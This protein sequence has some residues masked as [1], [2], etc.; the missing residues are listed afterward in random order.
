M[1]QKLYLLLLLVTNSIVAQHVDSTTTKLSSFNDDGYIYDERTYVIYT[2]TGFTEILETK[3]QFDTAFVFTSASR[4]DVLHE[5][6]EFNGSYLSSTTRWHWDSGWQQLNRTMFHYD[7]NSVLT[8][9]VYQIYSGTWTDSAR[10]V[11]SWLASGELTEQ[12]SQMWNGSSWDNISRVEYFF[13]TYLQDT[14]TINYTGSGSVWTPTQKIVNQY[15]TLAFVI[16]SST[17][18]T[19]NVSVWENELLHK[20]SYGNLYTDIMDSTFSWDGSNWLPLTLQFSHI[21]NFNLV[22]STHSSEWNGSSWDSTGYNLY[23]RTSVSDYNYQSYFYNGDGTYSIMNDFTY[24]YDLF[25]RLISYSYD[26]HMGSSMGYFFY[27]YDNDG[28][29]IEFSKSTS[30]MGGIFGIE[31]SYYTKVLHSFNPSSE[32]I[33]CNG[34]SVT[35]EISYFGGKGGNTYSWTGPG[36]ISN[37][38]DAV[39]I[40]TPT[41]DSYFYVSIADTAGNIYK[42]SVHVVL[43]AFTAPDLGDDTTLCN[44]SP[45]TL[46]VATGYD[47]YLW[48]DS[49]QSNT[50]YV[51][52][53]GVDTVLCTVSV[54]LS[55]CSATDSIAIYFDPCANVLNREFDTDF[56]VYPNPTSGLF[57]IDINSPIYDDHYKVILTDLLG[58]IVGDYNFS[59]QHFSFNTD[60]PKGIYFIQ[61]HKKNDQVVQNKM[62]V[63][64]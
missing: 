29:L 37:A 39:P 42:D 22:D 63:I 62:L 64:E 57:H 3:T 16:T 31:H 49:S 8:D 55:S 1:K 47:T 52:Y 7:A 33:S 23:M 28:F 32:Y 25:G 14:L 43:L 60:L 51:E 40:I 27:T 11:F 10:W 41:S 54:T 15:D 24:N 19:Y 61:L 36:V 45:I 53:L 18:Y 50:L 46:Q 9:S 35:P 13:D 56:Q 38:S 20:Y 5:V 34:V 21:G 2:D 12:Y 17:L 6:K 44:S 58:K 59:A 26:G 4:F 48:Q 30:T